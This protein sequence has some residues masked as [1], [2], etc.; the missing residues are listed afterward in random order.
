M[1]AHCTQSWSVAPRAEGGAVCGYLRSLESRN[2]VCNSIQHGGGGTIRVALSVDKLDCQ[3][4]VADGGAPVT[5]EL[6][7]CAFTAQGQVAAKSSGGGRYSR[8]LGLFVATVAAEA[9]GARVLATEENGHNAFVLFV[10]LD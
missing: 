5:Q 3:I 8:G 10:P 9:A 4:V 6:R 2:L 1:R 7:D